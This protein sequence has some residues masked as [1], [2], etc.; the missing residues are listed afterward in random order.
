MDTKT[1]EDEFYAAQKLVN[2]MA[3]KLN[4]IKNGI[5]PDAVSRQDFDKVMNL[6][7]EIVANREKLQEK[8]NRM[9]YDSAL[10]HNELVKRI[11]EIIRK[12]Q[13]QV[14]PLEKLDR[15]QTPKAQV[16]TQ[17]QTIIRT[18]PNN[19]PPYPEEVRTK[20]SQDQ[21]VI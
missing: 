15:D 7:M 11:S 19:I 18:K 3:I 4:M 5:D 8:I 6:N 21:E 17:T 12:Y 2:E 16:E 10:E 1:Y 9:N 20:Q 13:V 14:Q